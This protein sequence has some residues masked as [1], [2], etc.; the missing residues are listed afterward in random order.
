MTSLHII[1]LWLLTS[2]VGAKDDGNGGGGS[3]RQLALAY[4][5]FL[6][7]AP[8]ECD[9]YVNRCDSDCCCDQVII[10]FSRVRDSF[11]L[12]I[13]TSKIRDL[14]YMGVSPFSARVLWF[15]MQIDEEF[16][17]FYDE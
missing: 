4:P 10:V 5:Q 1:I 6:D 17:Y 12:K 9:L 16:N 13:S 7:L 8:C 11:L 15:G 3:R 2:R 14:F